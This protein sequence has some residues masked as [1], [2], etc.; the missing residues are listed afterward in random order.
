MRR[1]PVW[2][3]LIALA[4]P[5]L[6]CGDDDGSA[7]ER[8]GGEAGSD[9]VLDRL[10]SSMEKVEDTPTTGRIALRG[11]S[12]E[13][14]RIRASGTFAME[15]D[16][17]RLRA[18]YVVNGEA[19]VMEMISHEDVVWMRM[20][21]IRSALPPGKTWIR[22][23]DPEILGSST[24]SPQMFGDL[25][26]GAGRVEDL[27]RERVRGVTARHLRG[28]VDLRKAAEKVSTQQSE[29]FLRRLGDREAPLPVDVWIGP[30]G[31][32][33]RYHVE[34]ELPRPGGGRPQFAVLDGVVHEYDAPVDTEPPPAS[35]VTDDS[36]L[37]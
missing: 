3:I 8:G 2:L 24:M 17:G 14:G 25:L 15:G 32:P 28:T 19:T 30:D 33:V 20:P 31:R 21:Q 1:T 34:V 36:I 5:V 29:T 10:I 26:Q 6:G 7:R 16:R 22:S 12:A 23:T 13:D 18:R 11:D 9:D 4:W 35:R 37:E 27:G